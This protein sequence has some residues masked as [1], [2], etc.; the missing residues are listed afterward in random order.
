[1]TS[2]VAETS[3]QLVPR[4]DVFINLDVDLVSIDVAFQSLLP[5]DQAV[6]AFGPTVLRLVE[7]IA[8]A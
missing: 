7:T 3:R 8:A 1:M 5:A 2:L 6:P 4:I